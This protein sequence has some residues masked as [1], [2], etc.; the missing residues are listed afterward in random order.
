MN[1]YALVALVVLAIAAT[2]QYYL[3]TKKNRVLTSRMSGALEELLKPG[4]TNY[5]NI[6]GTIGYNV[7]TSYS[8]HYT[9]LYEDR[10]DIDRASCKS[11]PTVLSEKAQ[12]VTLASE[13]SMS[14]PVS[15]WL[16]AQYA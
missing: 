16:I 4:N 7:I 13:P 5:V 10:A 15:A 12:L 8:I 9:K 1:P 11:S 14:R 3:G 6:G 2:A